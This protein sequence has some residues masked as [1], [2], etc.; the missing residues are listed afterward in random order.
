MQQLYTWIGFGHGAEIW[1]NFSLPIVGIIDQDCCLSEATSV[2]H[3][4]VDRKDRGTR[5]HLDPDGHSRPTWSPRSG[6][7]GCEE[8]Q[9]AARNC[10]P[11]AG[12]RGISYPADLARV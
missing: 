2:R 3:E 8:L 6:Y 5:G 1:A 12:M 10:A 4:P 9:D 7:Q 11:R